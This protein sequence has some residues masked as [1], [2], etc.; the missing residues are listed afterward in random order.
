MTEDSTDAAR[1]QYGA[2]DLGT[3]LF[4]ALEQAGKHLDSLTEEDLAPVEEMHI[5]GRLVTL[6]MGQMAGLTERMRVVDV[7]CGIG[8]AARGIAHH[9]GCSVTGVELME[10]FCALGNR[11]TEMVAMGD[12]VDIRR[13]NALDLPLDSDSF[14]AAWLQHV[15]VSIA[16][17]AALFGEIARVLKPKGRLVLQEVCAGPLPEPHYPLPWANRADSSFLVTPQELQDEMSAAGFTVHRWEDVSEEC[18]GYPRMLQQMAA[19]GGLPTL[20]PG[21]LRGPAFLKLIGNL[22]QNL[23][24]DRLKI[25]RAVLVLAS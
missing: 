21:T 22:Q 23:D 14:D 20:G 12:K 2:G 8:G 9:F 1:R 10:D 11:L 4:T 19:E 18:A 24:E 5:G 6:K 13:G 15:A 25:V 17:K 3:R 7:G 16:D